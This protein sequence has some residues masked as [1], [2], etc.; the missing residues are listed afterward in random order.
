MRHLVKAAV[1]VALVAA[2]LAG[3]APGAA[4]SSQLGM[5]TTWYSGTVC[6][7]CSVTKH[8]NDAVPGLIYT[9]GYS[10][11]GATSVEKCVFETVRTWYQQ[12]PSGEREFWFTLKNASQIA[13]GTN[14]MLSWLASGA[15]WSS[16]GLSPGESATWV[17]NNTPFYYS[18]VAGLEPSGATSATACQFEVTRNWYVRQ[19]WDEREFWFVIKNVG[20]I[21]CQANILVGWNTSWF[22]TGATTGMLA[23]GASV[24]KGWNHVPPAIIYV[25]NALPFNLTAPAPCQFEITRTWYTQQPNGEREYHYIYKN[26]GTITCEASILLAE[27]TA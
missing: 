9:V 23:P 22:Y 20:T 1:L 12:L 15:A 21:T 5:G 17:W 24:T 10:P 19:P 27:S 6:A 4:A 13:C 16:G 3:P 18:F 2:T 25:P 14:I 7:G 8:W 11:A 26:V